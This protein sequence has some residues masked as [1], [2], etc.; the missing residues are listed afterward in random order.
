MRFI[1]PGVPETAGQPGHNEF[2]VPLHAC[3]GYIQDAHYW[4]WLRWQ[5]CGS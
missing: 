3:C 5:R 2:G 4:V 1:P